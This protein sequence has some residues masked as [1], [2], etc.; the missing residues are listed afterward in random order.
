MCGEEDFRIPRYFVIRI[1]QG[2]DVLEDARCA[3][4]PDGIVELRLFRELV[5]AVQGRGEESSHLFLRC[6]DRVHVDGVVAVVRSELDEIV[7]IS[8]DVDHLVL[9]HES[10]KWVE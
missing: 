3:G 7:L 5:G 9:V 1:A 8:D 4:V 6:L 2:V 10:E